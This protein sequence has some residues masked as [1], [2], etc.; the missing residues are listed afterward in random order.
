MT[1]RLLVVLLAIFSL[2]GAQAEIADDA[3]H[4]DIYRTPPEIADRILMDFGE[5]VAQTA[6]LISHTNQLNNRSD[7]TRAQHIRTWRYLQDQIQQTGKFPYTKLSL[8]FYPTTS[9]YIRRHVT[10]DVV[11]S[12]D[13]HRFYQFL[14]HPTGSFLDPDGVLNIWE[15]YEKIGFRLLFDGKL[16]PLK[17]CPVHHCVFGFEHPKLKPYQ[18]ILTT[19]ARRHKDQLIKILREDCHDQKRARSALLLAHAFPDAHELIGGLL[20]SIRDSD[21]SVRNNVM[22]V[23]AET[24]DKTPMDDFPVHDVLPALDF[25]DTTDRNKA[26]LILYFLS[27]QSAS[28]RSTIAQHASHR[29]V[30]L[31]RLQQPNLHDTAYVLLKQI[32]G[33]EYGERDYPEWESWLNTVQP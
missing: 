7:Q 12:N 4:V 24:L 8:V 5:K 11:D 18:S 26:L 15:K 16:Q 21:G 13:L 20:P 19:Q 6:R 10:I 1:W 25:P 2:S 9:G 28:Y 30:D 27:K 17:E 22:R 33:K 14:P 3:V 23:I 31:L 32:G 29:L